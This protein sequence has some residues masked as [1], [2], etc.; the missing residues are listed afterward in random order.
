MS[1]PNCFRLRAWRSESSSKRCIAPTWQA[2]S[3][4]RSQSMDSAKTGPPQKVPDPGWKQVG[5]AK[6][7][8]SRE[9]ISLDTAGQSFRYYLIWITKLP[10]D[11][12]KVEIS[13]VALTR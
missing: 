1:W 13:E 6:G 4:A 7:I 9:P 12:K 11:Q 5:G 3:N 10:P 8:R 2:P